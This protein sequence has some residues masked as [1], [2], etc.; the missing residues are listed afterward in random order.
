MI[1]S[2]HTALAMV[3]AMA[4]TSAVAAGCGDN[5]SEQTGAGV[6]AIVFIYFARMLVWIPISKMLFSTWSMKTYT[7]SFWSAIVMLA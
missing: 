4:G 6:S 3:L 7:T 5:S 2:R 1:T